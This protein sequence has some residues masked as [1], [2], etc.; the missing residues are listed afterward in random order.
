M[1]KNSSVVNWLLEENQP[2]IRYLTLTEL[3]GKAERD[4]DVRSS[5]KDIT[6]VGFAKDVL[7]KQLPGGF[8]Y[9]EKSLFN[10]IYLATFW[11]L[12]ILITNTR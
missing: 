1:M 7:D 9:H 2:S 5:K 11:M 3:L 8:W 6:K 12:L 10:P 4:P